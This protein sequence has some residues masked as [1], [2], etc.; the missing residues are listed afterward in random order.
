MNTSI[1]I[2]HIRNFSIVAHIDHGKSTISDRILELTHTVDE[3]DMES[4]LLDTMDIERERGITIKSNAVRVSYDADDGETYQFNLIDTPGH[5]DF[6]YEVSRSLAA[7]EGAVLV[8]DATQGVEAQTVSNATLAMNANLDIVPAINK[9]DLP[10]AHPDEVKTEIEDDLAIPADDAVCVS[11]KTGEG[12]HDLLESIV[13]LISP[14]KGDANAPLKALILDSYFDEYRGVV[15]TVRVFDGSIKKGD[16]LRMMQAEGDFLVD[17]VGVKRPAETPVD[18]LTVGEVGYVVTGLKDPEA[19]RVGDTLTWAS[20]PCPEPLPGYREAK[21]MVYT[22]LFPID[23]KDYENLRDAL[24]KLHVNDP[25]LVWE[26][27]TSVALGFGF[28]VGFLGLLHMEVVKERLEREFN[29][30]LIAT[31]PSVDYHVYKTDGEMIDVRSPQDLPEATRIER[32]EEPYLKAKI[33]CPPEYTGAVMQLA[34]EHRGIT[35]DMI[36]LTS[37]SVEMRFDMPLAELILDFFDQLK[38][39]TKGYASLDYEF[40]EYRP[41]ELVKLDILLSGDEVDALSFIVH[42]DKAYGLARGL[43]DKLKEIIPRQLFEV[44]IQGAIGNKIIARS[45][46]KA[47]RKDVLAKCYGGDISRKRKLLEKQKEGK[48]RMKAIGSVEVPQ[49]AFMAILKVDE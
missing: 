28:R 34:I 23:N 14:P 35:T 7:C 26:P 1:D 43:C 31:S 3:R 45:T 15:A 25:S 22:G 11:G 38:S 12:I 49:E 33:I 27:E 18:A 37:K 39:R 6:T 8:V 16:T 5:V 47:R 42:K 13:F 44:P 40:N 20:N 30:D 21:P 36:H 9:I 4:Q 46:V 2:S 29:L 48:K 32:I 10:S 41:S 17:G 24:D 19:V